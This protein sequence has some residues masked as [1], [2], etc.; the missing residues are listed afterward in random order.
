[1]RRIIDICFSQL[2]S[3]STG[4]RETFAGSVSVLV[5]AMLMA[6]TL[7]NCSGGKVET[8][9]KRSLP[10][11]NEVNTE[12]WQKLSQRKVFFGHQSVGLNIFEGIEDLM[13]VNSRI[14]LNIIESIKPCDFVTPVFSHYPI[15]MNTNPKSKCD[16][17][18]A[19]MNSGLGDKLDVAFF[20]FCYVDIGP[21]TNVQELF[22][23][24]RK[25]MTSMRGKYPR[26]TFVHVTVPL[27]SIQTGPKAMLKTI[28]G[29]PLVGHED[30]IK[31][32]EY[33]TML[34]K[35]YEGKEPVFDLALIE[36]ILPDGSRSFVERNGKHYPCLA[37][38]YT[39]D[40]GHLNETGR[41]HVAEQFLIFLAKLQEQ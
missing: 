28:L 29:R 37:P 10:S 13:R 7:N 11:I 4:S 16:V 12:S 2:R 34:R 27:T 24:Y 19:F 33:N 23:A 14:K 6:L 39:N 9:D 25:T 18:S 1:M 40:G 30:N 3:I 41:K 38:Q 5:A 22:D 21:H 15:G 35:E 31:R 32:E 17:F 8:T 36:S 26:M 20:K